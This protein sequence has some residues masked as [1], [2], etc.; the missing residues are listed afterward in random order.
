[1]PFWIG[2]N[3]KARNVIAPYIGVGGKARRVVK[4]YI[5]VDNKARL[6]YDYLDNIDHVEIEFYNLQY[7][8]DFSTYGGTKIADGKAACAVYGSSITL[9]ENSGAVTAHLYAKGTTTNYGTSSDP[10]YGGLYTHFRFYAVL[11]DGYRL[12][13]DFPKTN[14]AKDITLGVTLTNFRTGSVSW[15]PFIWMF[16]DTDT[17]SN[18]T[19]K[20]ATITLSSGY[21]GGANQFLYHSGSYAEYDLIF[22]NPVIGGRAYTLKLKDSIAA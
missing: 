14:D 17:F 1:M 13:L 9:S 2:V 12:R 15:Y 19:S 5:G 11:K 22:Q 6:F 20:S 10:S 4:G 21:S 16:G 3:G 18:S 8:T 7:Y